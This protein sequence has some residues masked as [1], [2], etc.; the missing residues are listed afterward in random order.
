MTAAN[1]MQQQ[2]RYG[3]RLNG[4]T[5][6]PRGTTNTGVAAFAAAADSQPPSR[7]NVADWVAITLDAA[8]GT[9]FKFMRKGVY[10]FDVAI[11]L[12]AGELTAVMIG[13]SL[14]AANLL[15]AGVTPAIALTSFEDYDQQTGVGTV[16]RTLKLNFTVHITNPER[17]SATYATTAPVGTSPLGTARIHIGDGAGNAVTAA[18]VIV[19]NASLRLNSYAELFG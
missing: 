19:A 6:T 12:T 13:G 17:S 11:P 7:P 16:Q 5:A 4:L 18:S 1:M 3:R 15:A 14:D 9:T 10:R 2:V 8:A